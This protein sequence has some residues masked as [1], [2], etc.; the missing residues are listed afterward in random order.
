MEDLSRELLTVL[1]VLSAAAVM[2]VINRPRGDM[3]AL[4]VMLSL[5]LSGVLTLN[6][7]LAGFSEPVVLVIIVMFIIGEALRHTGVTHWV[8]EAV[9]RAGGGI[10]RRVLL[11]LMLVVGG[12]GAFMSSTAVVAL[13]IP[14]VLA[15]ERE[16]GLNRKRLLMPLAFAALISGMMTLIATAPNLI[17]N[18]AL[19]TRGLPPFGFFSFTPFGVA[20]LIAGVCYILL[21][22]RRM[23]SREKRAQTERQ[24]YSMSDLFKIYGFQDRLMRLRILSGS[25]LSGQR[26]R[27]SRL[28]ERYGISLSG[29]ERREYGKRTFYSID[30]DIIFKTG[31][32]IYLIGDRDSSQRFIADEKLEVL[33]PLGKQGRRQAVQEL[34]FAE[35]M[36]TPGSPLI[37]QTLKK[38]R[39]RSSHR[40]A[41]L[42]VRRRGRPV[43][44][45]VSDLQ[46]DFGDVLLISGSWRDI[47]KLR[48]EQETFIL[49]TLPHEYKSFP[50]ARQNAGT[51][52]AI[53]VAMLAAIASGLLPMVVAVM[54]AALAL[55]ATRCVRLEAVYRVVNWQSVV[56]IVGMLPLATAL[57]KTGAADLAAGFLI[58]IIGQ[59]GPL[60]MLAVVFLLTS[61]TGLFISNSATA[62]II[63]PV[64]ID[65]ALTIGVPP[66]AFA[67]TV[68][69]A[70]SAS[71][72]T[73]V[74]S[75]ANTLV[76][77]PGGYSFMDF[78]KVGMPLQVVALVITVGLSWFLYMR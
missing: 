29:Y 53:L 23:L 16:V 14:V 60:G 59:M 18:S 55:V 25:P 78:V 37:G 11:C 51:A 61:I 9:V 72:V 35:V 43:L 66:E 20:I 27:E 8:G 65:V 67:M 48:S 52:M 62:I 69:S 49:L 75:P 64:A 15:I 63:A 3:V 73:P 58:G 13:F 32:I 19:R 50:A 33:P 76:M 12:V 41:V 74:S 4:M 47:L 21:F 71:Y 6:E 77:D 45:N 38:G 39:F 34:G 2:F 24:Q 46:L 31:D 5:M 70:C 40:V 36:L 56:L 1:G 28:S 26:I 68:A 10:E 42:A 30:P 54:S 57:N 44:T 17:V 22:G 7:A